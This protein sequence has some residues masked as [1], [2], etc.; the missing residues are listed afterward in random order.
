MKHPFTCIVSGPTGCGKT[1]LVKA[2][3][4]EKVIEPTP[5]NILWLYAADQPLYQGMK[6]V[7]FHNGI[8]DDIEDRFNPKTNNLLIIDDLM[9]QCHS[10]ERMTRLFSVGSSHNNLSIIFIVHNLFH[11]G[12]EMRN[13]SLNTHYIILF[14][15]P[16]DSQQISTL[17]RQMYPGKS[18]FLI[19]AYQD[20]TKHPHGYLFIDL[21]PS[22]NEQLRIRTGILPQ[23]T[24][25][26]YVNKMVYEEE[27][28]QSDTKSQDVQTT[29]KKS[30]VSPYVITH[31]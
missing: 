11:H 14:K 3:I 18:Q 30:T 8:P 9:T 29:S 17:A 13:I 4:E 23:D 2:I 5:R 25:Y 10:D 28:H 16:R 22:T 26:V 1:S 31:S 27:M 15:N 24:P 19:E 7:H 20:A 12:K 6:G 21:K